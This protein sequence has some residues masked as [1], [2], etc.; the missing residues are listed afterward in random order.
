MASSPQAAAAP[1]AVIRNVQQWIDHPSW[2]SLTA[3]DAADEDVQ[4]CMALFQ[5]AAVPFG[6]T[7][8]EAGPAAKAGERPA[9]REDRD[10]EP[11]QAATPERFRFERVLGVGGFGVVLC[12][13]DQLRQQ[14][15]ALKLLRP[16]LR[17]SRVL[18]RRFLREVQVSADLDCDGIV[19]VLETG[20]LNGHPYIMTAVVDGLDLARWMHEH[21]A[22][23]PIAETQAVRLLAPVAAA[24]QYAHERGVLHRDLKPSNIL[25]ELVPEETA[26]ADPERSPGRAALLA[27][28]HPKLT[29]FGLA[30]RV[31][32]L[33]DLQDNLSAGCQFLGTLRYMSPEQAAGRI[34]DVGIASDVYALGAI[35][36][37]CLTGTTPHDGQSSAEVLTGILH[38]TVTPPRRLNAAVSRDLENVVLK[39]LAPAPHD[40]YASAGELAAELQRVQRGEPVLARQAGWLRRL[41]YWARQ[42][43][44]LAVVSGALT[45]V[46][47][48]ALLVISVLY[49]QNYQ[50]NR[51]LERWKGML[52]QALGSVTAAYVEV[53]EEMLDSVPDSAEERYQLHLRALETQQRL[54]EEFGNDVHRRYQL[55]V[56]YSL[57]GTAA[58][59]FGRVAEARRHRDQ[60]LALLEEL[61]REDP[62]NLEYQ[63]DLFFNRK[64]IA[65]SNPSPL[66]SDQIALKE[67]VHTDICRLV[68]LAPDNPYFQDAAASTR[69]T[70]ARDYAVL[71]DPRTVPY[72]E[73]SYRISDRLWQQYP[74]RLLF[75]KY[76]L[77]SRALLADYLRD[78]GN[79][80]ESER[81]C[82]EGCALL[83]RLPQ[84]DEEQPWLLMSGLQLQRALAETCFVQQ[85]WSEAASV[86]QECVALT[87]RLHAHYPA[88]G[89]WI[90][91]RGQFLAELL[92]AERHLGL[93]P[94]REAELRLLLD[95]NL[96][97]WHR[98]PGVEDRLTDLRRRLDDLSATSLRP[99]R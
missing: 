55:S 66:L 34:Q 28:Y 47:G 88:N 95:E 4:I 52:D 22:A 13:F 44:A 7:T 10:D 73:E 18:G 83:Q 67:Q 6:K 24:L 74:Q 68:A 70:V 9:E 1:V 58:E 11:E 90:I 84:P 72:L 39:C 42:N 96:A 17:R 31:D 94:A 8:A 15:V 45:A 48:A 49:Y 69:M 25:L 51:T 65:D 56:L 20:R 35:L 99:G 16:S 76:A 92:R 37:Q 85:N 63:Y 19:K 57:T 91:N 80:A 62:E 38:G 40:R 23:V 50:A 86:L 53:A 43:P 2:D 3:A 98:F 75:V 71:Q 81:L 61:L 64:A 54:T 60:C 97:E 46:A 33:Q 5:G 89:E 12:V 79:L 36:Y 14:R 78:Q 26:A 59:R 21:A 30:K 29:D 82:R 87:A 77:E 41:R 32:H 27:S 93:L